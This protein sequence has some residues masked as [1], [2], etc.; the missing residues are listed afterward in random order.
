MGK[1]IKAAKELLEDMTF[2]NYNYSSE[3]VVLKR[4]SGRYE[5]DVVTLLASK[6]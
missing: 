3:R 5:V 1:S 6:I 2:N 4:S